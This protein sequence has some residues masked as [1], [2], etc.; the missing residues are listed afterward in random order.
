MSSRRSEPYHRK[1]YSQYGASMGRRS[2]S[3]ASFEG[4]SKAR[5]CRVPL[6]RGGYDPGG[7]YWGTPSNLWCATAEGD[8]YQLEHYLRAPSREAAKAKFPASV[9]W[10][11]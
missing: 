9:K 2:D 6:D 1:G 11:R 10:L 4:A 5:L 3:V 7:A 8:E